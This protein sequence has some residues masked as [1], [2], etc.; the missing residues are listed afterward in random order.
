MA[1]ILKR[2]ILGPAAART[3][4]NGRI[5]WTWGIR[6]KSLPLC[7]LP[8]CYRAARHPTAQLL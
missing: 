2:Q 7:I 5:V 1:S 8:L 4:R 6:L 3:R